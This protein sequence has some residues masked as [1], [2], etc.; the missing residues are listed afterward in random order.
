MNIN[1]FKK[2]YD[3]GLN[4]KELAKRL[5]CSRPTISFWRK[6][7]NLKRH[8]SFSLLTSNLNSKIKLIDLGYISGLLDGEGCIRL[9][10]RNKRR[11]ITPEIIIANTNEKVL[12]WLKD[13]L[14]T[15]KIYKRSGKFGHKDIFQYKITKIKE[16][17]D[18]LKIFLPILKIKNKVASR[19]L[20]F[21]ENRLRSP[22]YSHY[23][24]EEF[25]EIEVIKNL[26][27]RGA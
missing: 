2:F 9:K 22:S 23:T 16:V 11:G 5:N 8:S 17:Y 19:M 10:K 7:L 25:K 14:R 13:I 12:I 6:K 1:L 15:G 3:E 18:F 20:K 26:N 27:K 21:T 4:D 24:E